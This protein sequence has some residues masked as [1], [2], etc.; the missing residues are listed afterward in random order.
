MYLDRNYTGASH[1]VDAAATLLA[2]LDIDPSLIQNYTSV[3]SVGCLNHLVAKATRD[4][5]MQYWHKGNNPSTKKN[6]SKVMHTM[7]REE[8]NNFVAPLS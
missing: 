1:D 5:A 3:M 6:L 2:Y 4:N 8:C 7:N